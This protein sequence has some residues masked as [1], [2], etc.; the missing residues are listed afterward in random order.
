MIMTKPISIFFLVSVIVYVLDNGWHLQT[1]PSESMSEISSSGK[2]RVVSRDVVA[3]DQDYSPK[4]QI[5]IPGS[6]DHLPWNTQVRYGISVSDPKDGDS[7]FGEIDARACLMEIEYF[8]VVEVSQVNEVSKTGEEHRG[9]SLMKRSTCFG[10][11]ADKTRLAGPSFAEI[12]SRYEKNP[13]TINNLASHVIKGSSG[14]WGSQMMPSH[15]DLTLEEAAQIAAYMLEQGRNKNRWI[16]PGLEGT[17][18]V[19]EKPEDGKQGIYVLTA[20][21]TS[22]SNIRGEHRVVLKI[23]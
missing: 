9:L 19:I 15:P 21:Y 7:Q 6:P 20:S 5:E 10:C 23:K 18:R 13:V 3:V 16:Y 11:H 14:I 4:V 8:P 2:G 17:F 12:A 1:G 22:T